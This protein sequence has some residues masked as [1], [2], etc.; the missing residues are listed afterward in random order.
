MSDDEQEYAKAVAQQAAAAG[1]SGSAPPTNY[2]HSSL[3]GGSG[4][5]ND[6]HCRSTALEIAMRLSKPG[7]PFPDVIGKARAIY[8]FLTAGSIAQ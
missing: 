4:F 3:Y 1:L 7:D 8:D 2:A 6:I 5:Y